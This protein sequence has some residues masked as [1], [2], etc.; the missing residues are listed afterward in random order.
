MANELEQRAK[1][2]WIAEHRHDAGRVT[3]I[4][5]GLLTADDRR[6]LRAIVAALQQAQQPGAQAVASDEILYTY[7]HN[8]RPCSAECCGGC[9]YRE[10]TISPQPPLP[11]GV[12]KLVNVAYQIRLAHQSSMDSTILSC[13]LFRKLGDALES[14]RARLATK[15]GIVKA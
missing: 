13:E 3:A 14:Y 2:L 6:A 15:G 10:Y 12:N 11:E 7:D 1:E 4:K 8:A 5:A 9:A